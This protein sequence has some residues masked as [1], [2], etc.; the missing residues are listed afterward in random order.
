[1]STVYLV[2]H[3]QA[4]FGAA[5]YDALSPIGIE[6]SRALGSWAAKCMLE[7]DRVLVG[8]QQRHAQTAEQCWKA[9]RNGLPQP[10]LNIDP[11]F[12]EFDHLEV[13]HRF[14]PDLSGQA[15]LNEW[16]ARTEN[17]RRE[18]QKVFA[19]AF[20]RW[21]EGKHDGYRESFTSFRSRC[22]QALL[23]LADD[24]RSSEAIWIFT[25]AGP[26]SAI[27]QQAL[28]IADDRIAELTWALVNTGLTKLRWRGGCVR[29]STINQYA[30]LEEAHRSEWVTYR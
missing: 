28:A 10:A 18:F 22:W 3:G 17:P 7:M 27:V 14:R 16:L 25:S 29:V 19:Q 15:A 20:A 6:Q 5:D 2:R 13:L 21:V 24:G 26:I 11:G 9:C 12:S 4:S 30:H 8:E 23:R 1:M